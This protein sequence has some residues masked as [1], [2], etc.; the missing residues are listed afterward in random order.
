MWVLSIKAEF[1]RRTDSD[2]KQAVSPIL[3]N[4]MLLITN[5]FQFVLAIDSKVLGHPLE[6]DW[7]SGSYSLKMDY[8][9]PRSHQLFS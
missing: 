4:L 5:L 7:Q 2:F 6:H 9:S 1:S 8:F 3:P